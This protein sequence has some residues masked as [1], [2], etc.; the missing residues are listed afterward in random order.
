MIRNTLDNGNFA[1]GV[2]MSFW[3]NL[4]QKIKIFT[5]LC[6]LVPRLI[7]TYRI[8]WCDTFICFRLEIPFLGKIWSKKSKLYISTEI[9][10]LD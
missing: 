7:R 6:N 2:F 1:C 3:A 10:Y 9:R 4:V 5:L 8:Q